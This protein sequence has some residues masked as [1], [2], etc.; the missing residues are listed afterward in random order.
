MIVSFAALDPS[1]AR[2]YAAG[3]QAAARA[4]LL[5][6]SVR[7]LDRCGARPWP[8]PLERQRARLAAG[9]CLFTVAAGYAVALW[10]MR[11][12]RFSPQS[13]ASRPTA[14]S[15]SSPRDP[16]LRPPSGYCRDS[17]HSGKR[18]RARVVARSRARCDLQPAVFSIAPSRRTNSSRRAC[19]LF[20]LRCAGPMAARPG[21]LLRAKP[22]W[23]KHPRR[24]CMAVPA[25]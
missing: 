15:T 22:H 25:R 5:A 7:T 23:G 13:F 24:D 19:G 16:R 4:G 17:Y 1:P 9:V 6:G 14:A 12:N 21:H 2:T 10:A 18:T 20:G 8:F 11:V 3:R